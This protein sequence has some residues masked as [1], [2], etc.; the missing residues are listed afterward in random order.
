MQTFVLD[1]IPYEPDLEK[2]R[3]ELHI[4]PGTE[5]DAE[6]EEL[7]AEARGIAKP[8]GLYGLA[9]IDSEDETVVV[10]EGVTFRS[11]VLRIN[12]DQQHETNRW[13]RTVRSWMIKY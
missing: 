8:K 7:A 3:A 11:R 10:V 1:D 4:K 9:F 2:L 5:P 13:V 12:L 6:L